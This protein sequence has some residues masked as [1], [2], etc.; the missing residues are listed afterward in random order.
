MGK[1]ASN[2][3]ARPVIASAA[4]V[5]SASDAAL[6]CTGPR[7]PGVVGV[8]TGP[9]VNPRRERTWSLG[10]NLPKM[11]YLVLKTPGGG[12]Y[13]QRRGPWRHTGWV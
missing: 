12:R 13:A 6:G 11:G 4:S 1:A 5:R 3:P 2:A 8:T 9:G 10:V 7:P